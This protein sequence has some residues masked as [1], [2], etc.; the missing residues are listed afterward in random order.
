MI[1]YLDFL[2]VRNLAEW[3]RNHPYALRLQQLMRIED[4][5]YDTFRRGIEHLDPEI[6]AN[7]VAGL[8]KVTS[9]LLYKQLMRLESDFLKEGGLRERMTKARLAQRKRQ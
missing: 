8:I 5:S 3:D 4:G 7:V 6:S 1:D 9:Y 2:R